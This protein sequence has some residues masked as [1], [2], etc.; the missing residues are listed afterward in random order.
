MEEIP[1]SAKTR[2][3]ILAKALIAE[4]LVF[5]LAA[6]AL[7][8]PAGTLLWYPG[9]IFLIA[10]FGFMATLATYL[11]K[12][13]P[14]LLAERIVLVKVDEPAWDKPYQEVPDQI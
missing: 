1:D 5:V 11:S 14:G 9:W 8:V 12:H 6:M 10:F 13:D 3:H 7:F 4:L 2:R